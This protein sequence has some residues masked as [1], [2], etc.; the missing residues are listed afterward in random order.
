MA[1]VFY[2]DMLKL[3]ILSELRDLGMS[4]DKIKTVLLNLTNV[5]VEVVEKQ[6]R[7]GPIPFLN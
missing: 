4:L 2:L 6:K 7:R 3:C 5:E 1:G